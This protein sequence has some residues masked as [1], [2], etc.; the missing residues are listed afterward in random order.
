MRKVA[1]VA[2]G[3]LLGTLATACGEGASDAGAGGA[4]G[5]WT[6]DAAKTSE[7][8]FVATK[9]QIEETR[10]KLA[11]QPEDVRRQMEARFPKDDDA[12]R[13][14]VQ[15]KT[16]RLTVDLELKPSGDSRLYIKGVVGLSLQEET[17]EGTWLER[18]GDVLVTPKTRNGKPLEKNEQ[19]RFARRDGHLVLMDPAGNSLYW[20][21]RK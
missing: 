5:T 4:A 6:I 2:G 20:L 3:L 11:D 12:L 16:G 13:A 8:A 17:Q 7:S 9:R 19:Q 15:A 14:D 21:A 18:D 10:R 1:T